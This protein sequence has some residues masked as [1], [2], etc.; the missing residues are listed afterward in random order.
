MFYKL[1]A[2]YTLFSQYSIPLARNN[3]FSFQKKFLVDNSYEHVHF[4]PL[5]FPILVS[6]QCQKRTDYNYETES[7]VILNSLF[8]RYHWNHS[9]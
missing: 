5:F 9:V 3:I 2:L 7:I 8:N 1:E 4:L 6:P